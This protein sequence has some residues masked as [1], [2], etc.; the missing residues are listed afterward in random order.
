MVSLAEMPGVQRLPAA[1]GFE[2]GGGDA[3]IG[4]QTI[5]AVTAGQTRVGMK[6]AED[7]AGRKL[8]ARLRPGL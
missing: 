8:L 7:Y 6:P 4:P 1:D 5:V 3:H 2:P